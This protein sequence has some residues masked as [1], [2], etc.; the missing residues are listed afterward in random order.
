MLEKLYKD[1]K[2]YLFSNFF[3][4]KEL[5]KIAMISKEFNMLKNTILQK[6]QQE[7]ISKLDRLPLTTLFE[8]GCENPT[9]ALLIVEDDMLRK[10]F[11]KSN[12]FHLGERHQLVRDIILNKEHIRNLFTDE[13]LCRLKQLSFQT[14]FSMCR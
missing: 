11:D 6:Q 9:A 3:T 4:N 8:Q 13:Q 10:K 1:I 7:L 5:R 12:L 2:L 14:V